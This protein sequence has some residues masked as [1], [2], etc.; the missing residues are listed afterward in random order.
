MGDPLSIT[1]SIIAILQ[2]TQQVI[3]YVV[4][5]KDAGDDRNRLLNEI[6]SAHGFLFVLKDKAE[7]FGIRW[8]DTFYVNMRTLNGPTGPL[9]QYKL[10]LQRLVAKLMP[11]KG[12]KKFGQ[13][14]GWP[15]EKK[16]IMEI[17]DTIER[18]KSLFSLALQNDNMHVF[19]SVFA[20]SS[21]LSN[22]IKH[23]V[24]QISD[25][26]SELQL[27]QKSKGPTISFV[28]R[29]IFIHISF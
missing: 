6:T 1:A 25:K 18:Q 24:D 12:L 2:L 8:D 14:L 15:F 17:L 10:A 29:F 20:D 19:W 26:L 3:Q 11:Q 5:A 4:D 13:I 28:Y 23:Q 9:E 22:A 7:K 21:A 16:E 27:K